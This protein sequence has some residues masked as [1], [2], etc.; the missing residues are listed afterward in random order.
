[1]RAT[2]CPAGAGLEIG[3]RQAEEM[4]E[5]AP[6]ELDV[7]PVG[8]VA[9]RIGAQEL[10]DRLEQAERHHADDQHDQ[11]R[12]ALVDQHLVDDELEE[13]RR[14]QREQLHEQ[15]GDQH[16]GER[17]AGSA[18]START[19]GSRRC[20]DRSPAPPSRRVISTS[21]PEDS[22]AISSSDSSC[23]VRAIGST[24]RTIP[25]VEPAP[26]TAKPP[27]FRPR[28]AG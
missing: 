5:Q 14:R 3:E 13:D 9:Q 12:H 16:M 20:W 22:A 10:Q 15:R 26:R 27:S 18:G 4:M 2:V 8:G 28:I 7:D 1:M 6:A 23:A 17:R 11:R 24:S 21:S 19:S 25:L